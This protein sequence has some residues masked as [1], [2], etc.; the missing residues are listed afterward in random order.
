M[1]LIVRL[2][3]A[4]VFA[5]IGLA[6]LLLPILPG[7]LFLFAVP[8]VLFPNSRLS[9]WALDHMERRMPRFGHRL[10]RLLGA[11]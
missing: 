1:M 10:R 6:G 4:S 8:L 2:L 5:V 11:A 9:R 3:I 7:W